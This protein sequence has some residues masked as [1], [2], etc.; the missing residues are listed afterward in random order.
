MNILSV[1]S[2]HKQHANGSITLTIGFYAFRRDPK[3]Q[4]LWKCR[5]R[6]LGKI[7]SSVNVP[8]GMLRGKHDAV[9]SQ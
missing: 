5:R 7:L 8:A 6:D 4:S 3:S 2:D 9:K 1:L